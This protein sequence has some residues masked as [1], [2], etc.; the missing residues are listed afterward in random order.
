MAGSITGATA[1]Y[2]LSVRGLYDDPQPLQGFAADDVFSTPAIKSV[3]TLMGVDGFLSGGYVFTE[4]VQTISLQADSDSCDIFDNWW[5]SQ[6]A[7]EDTFIADAVIRL[8]ALG[9]KWTMTRGFLTSYAPIPDVK[10][11]LQ[12]RKFEIT[13]N[14][15]SPSPI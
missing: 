4:I 6:Q 9:R 11:L 14:L 15:S 2:L 7:E 12:P 1:A 8:K 5:A 3:E 10:K 13:W